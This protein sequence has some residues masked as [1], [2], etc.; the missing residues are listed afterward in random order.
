M[1]SDE[2][3]QIM[4]RWERGKESTGQKRG[5]PKNRVRRGKSIESG[6]SPQADKH[7]DN[8][9]VK[10]GIGGNNFPSRQ[11]GLESERKEEEND[12]ER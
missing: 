6:D 7:N 3:V 2:L 4:K 8:K 9:N 12:L 5:I 10:M 11:D 1:T